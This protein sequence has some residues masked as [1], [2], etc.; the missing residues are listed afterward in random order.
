MEPLLQ[1]LVVNYLI[2]AYYFHK[3]GLTE[4]LRNLN[5]FNP[6]KA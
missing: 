1:S 5:I 4:E 2:W 6:P 3:E